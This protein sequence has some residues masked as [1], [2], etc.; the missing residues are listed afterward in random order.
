MNNRALPR[1]EAAVRIGASERTVDRLIRSQK[2]RAHKVGSRWKIFEADLDVYLGL[3]ANMPVSI[4]Q[5]QSLVI[6]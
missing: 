2:I 6:R 3:C 4:P 1:S 5:T